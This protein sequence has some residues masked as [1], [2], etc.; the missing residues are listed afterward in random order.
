MAFE[1]KYRRQV[2]LLVRVLPFIGEQSRFALKGGTAINLFV[3][4][5]PRLSVDIDLTYLPVG[6]R[7][8]S[9]KGIEAILKE[10]SE[11]VKGGLPN[12]QIH[13]GV[14]LPEKTVDKLYVRNLE[15]QIKVEVNPVLRGCVYD[16]E[17]RA[18]SSRV[19]DL[20]GFAE[21]QVVSFN[22]LYA[23]KIVAALDRQHPR[24]LFDVN[25]LM[26]KEG[27]SD[28]LRR[29]FVVY[30]LSSD[31]PLAEI[32]APNL[33]DISQEFE[34]GFV[35]MTEVPVKLEELL[36][37][38]KQLIATI[39]GGM[40]Q[41]H[42]DFLLSFQRGEPDWSLLDLQGVEELPAVRWRL[43]NQEKAS[44]ARKKEYFDSL[45]EVFGI[46]NE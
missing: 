29:A 9:L 18:V 14:L 33:K 26:S 1:E 35:G 15:A 43:L 37:T 32:L 36:D 20:F 5:M 6:D 23:G 10:I 45:N 13:E 19:S 4:E 31:R 28:D 2:D 3:R 46:A 21:M 30:L 40:P 34:N 16:P 24:D 8:P 39:V 41:A 38:R 22:D 12:I 27:I 11:K 25:L 44:P 7:M 17:T 42:R